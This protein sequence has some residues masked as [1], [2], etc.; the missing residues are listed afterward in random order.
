LD[1]RLEQSNT[2][3]EPLR[4]KQAREAARQWV[5]EEASG[6]P[7]F[8]GAYSAGSTNWLPGDA[9]LTTTSDFDI[10]VVLT[11][12]NQAGKRGKFVYR[13]I[14]LEVS[15]LQ[16]DQFQSSDLVYPDPSHENSRT[17]GH[18]FRPPG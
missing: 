4:V 16:N 5:V 11:D 10:M 12:P 7:G 14:L 1:S 9:D 18:R 8:C 2:L 17:P 15:Y 6:I 13:D 3:S